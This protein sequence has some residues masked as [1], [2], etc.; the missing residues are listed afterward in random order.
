M[1]A[2]RNHAT[3]VIL[4]ISFFLLQKTGAQTPWKI[5]GEKITTNWAA[6]VDYKNPLPEYPRP[7][8][9]RV[10]WINLNGLWDYAIKPITENIPTAYEGK[11]LVPFA[12][13]SALSGVGKEVGKDNWLWYRTKFTPP[14]NI[15]NKKLLL[16]FGAVDWRCTVY[17]NGKELN[18]HSGGYDP[19][20]FDITD[21]LK[22][23][24][25]ELV[26]RVWDPTDDGPQPRGKQVKNPNSIWYTPVTGIWQTVWLETVN[27]SHIENINTVSDID[28]NMIRIQTGL[29]DAKDGDQLK[30]SISEGGKIITDEIIN[31]GTMA[32][33]QLKDVKTW[34]PA[35]PFLYDLKLQLMRNGE[36]L[37]EVTSYF[38]MRKISLARDKNG[39]QRL[40]LNNEF[41]FQ[42]GM[43]DQGWW[44][45]GLYTAAT[46]EA[47][48]FDIV[49]AKA[50][51]FNMLR[52]HVKVEPSR[53]YYHCDKIGM[54]VWQDMPSGDMATADK[55]IT[56]PALEPF[57]KMRTPESEQIFKTELKT[58]MD[59]TKFFPCI[60]AWVPFNEAWGQFKTVEITGWVKNYDKSR[61]VNS[62][63][64]G[65]FF[66]TGDIHDFHNYPPPI[67]QRADLFGKNQAVVLGEYGGLGLP[68][69]G[70]TWQ[71]K[72]NWG[73]QS[74]KSADSLLIQYSN[75]VGLLE[76][77]IPK[78]LSAAIYTQVSDVEGEVNGLMTYDRKLIK[79]P[80]NKLNKVNSKLYKPL[81]Q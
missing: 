77:F 75:F 16:H 28:K 4:F 24:Q 51:G 63:S 21:Y 55:W 8:M 70:H 22:K 58:I 32:D 13:E 62:A 49:Q 23:G 59:A 73:Y 66:L 10:D 64:G 5:A 76:N 9:Q 12:V 18:T 6:S 69:E 17:I 43:L 20:Y 74:F 46:D 37:D 40:M 14:K 57:D 30:I 53:W 68:I 61:L 47:L 11:I 48:Q 60:V 65:N 72:A 33:V 80:V 39:I 71:N 79:I 7:Q 38:A 2:I 27:A 67:M 52:K 42:F 45:D 41:L 19:F 15:K 78:G 29:K 56:N 36:I 31:A 34:S 3:I 44:P 25:Q 35:N 50:M 54:L 26:V 81:S 1:I